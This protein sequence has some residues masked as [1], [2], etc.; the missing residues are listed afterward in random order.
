MLDFQHNNCSTIL[1]RKYPLRNTDKDKSKTQETETIDRHKRE[2]ETEKQTGN[3][4]RQFTF[5][6]FEYLKHNPSA[7]FEAA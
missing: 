3:T 6:Q 5:I 7:Q 4:K 2:T 1:H